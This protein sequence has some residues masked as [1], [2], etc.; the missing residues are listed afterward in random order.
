MAGV[1]E[2]E[3]LEQVQEALDTP[4]SEDGAMSVVE[5]SEALD[6]PASSVRN[7]LRKLLESGSI[8]LVRVRRTAM[9]GIVSRRV[10]YRTIKTDIKKAI[11]K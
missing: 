3:L 11:E 6:L 1:T 2:A 5:L 4:T 7:R 8:E 9:H 10:A